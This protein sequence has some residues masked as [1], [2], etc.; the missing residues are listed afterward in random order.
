MTL[1]TKVL[2]IPTCTTCKI[3]DIS[4]GR[5]DPSNSSCGNLA[6]STALG[7]EFINGILHGL[8]VEVPGE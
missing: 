2:G 5:T 6:C 4:H 1:E 8:F 3:W 7:D